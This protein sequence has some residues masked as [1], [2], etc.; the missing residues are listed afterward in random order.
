MLLTAASA[1]R[2]FNGLR[3][4]SDQ[5]GGEKPGKPDFSIQFARLG[6]SG[7]RSADSILLL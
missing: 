6:N 4:L 7:N 1:L 3:C 2:R 5:G